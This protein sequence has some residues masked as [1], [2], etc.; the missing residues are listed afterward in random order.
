MNREQELAHFRSLNDRVA[1]AVRAEFGNNEFTMEMANVLIRIAGQILMT[2]LLQ[3]ESE[4]AMA[5]WIEFQQN[6]VRNY[7]ERRDA[8]PDTMN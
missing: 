7:E 8:P 6:V 2:T 1:K 5:L 4:A 3:F